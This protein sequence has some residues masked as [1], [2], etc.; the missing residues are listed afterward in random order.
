MP[1]KDKNCVYLRAQN[2]IISQN[3]SNRSNQSNQKNR[4]NPNTPSIPSNQNKTPKEIWH[5]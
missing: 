3:T 4:S 2:N 1:K 5:K